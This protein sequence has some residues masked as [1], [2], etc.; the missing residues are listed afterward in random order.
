VYERLGDVRSVAITKGKIADIVQA[1]GDLDEALR[2]RKDEELPV[3][4]RLGDVRSVLVARANLAQMFWKKDRVAHA[5]EARRLLELALIDAQRLR[6]PE[7]AQILDLQ[8]AM[9]FLPMLADGAPAP[10]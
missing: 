2:I 10:G 5:D 8:A 7:V 6:L 9:G 4:E 3:L 1:R